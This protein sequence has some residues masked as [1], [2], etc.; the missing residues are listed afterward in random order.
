MKIH[1]TPLLMTVATVGAMFIMSAS[2][3]IS[4]A[5]Y[6]QTVQASAGSLGTLRSSE[7]QN[8]QSQSDEGLR[9]VGFWRPSVGDVTLQ[10]IQVGE[11]SYITGGIGDEERHALQQMAPNYNLRIMSALKSG[12]FAG[13]TR[14]IIRDRN[15]TELINAEAGPLF[16]ADLPAG[17]YTVEASSEGETKTKN[18]TVGNGKAANLN[19]SW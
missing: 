6:Q 3:N 9:D 13:D 4:L 1:A 17:R 5:A 10:P 12:N 8:L 14:V 19:F 18:V 11:A 2:E 7:I 16:F 15:G